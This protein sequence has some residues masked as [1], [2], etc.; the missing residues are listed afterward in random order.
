MHANAALLHRLF[1]AL[2]AR[3]HAAMA[4]CYRPRARFRDIA[5]DLDGREAIH[6][7]W[8]MICTGGSGIA[9]ERFEVLD[10]DETSGRARVVETY[11]F[12][13]STGTPGKPGRP[14][15]NDILSSFR[16][17][18]GRILRQDDECDARAW[19]RQALGNG[20]IGVLAGRIRLLRSRKAKAKL[21]AFL[22]ANPR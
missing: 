2:G 12:G 8:R 1:D 21:A 5:F 9:V 19:A 20:P 17:E 15:R 3:D 13:A 6:D 7:M 22:E 16:F 14:V 11:R 4:D 10:A 18:E